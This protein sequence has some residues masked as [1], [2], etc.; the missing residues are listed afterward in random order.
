M[1]TRS[2]LAGLMVAL[3]LAGLPAAPSTAQETPVGTAG[4]ADDAGL[5]DSLDGVDIGAPPPAASDYPDNAAPDAAPKPIRPAR[6]AAP[7]LLPGFIDSQIQRCWAAPV[8]TGD[9]G[10]GGVARIR[11]RFLPDGTLAE[12]PAI[13]DKPAGP[14]GLVFAESAAKAIAKCA[15]YK[16]PPESYESWKDVMLYF[17]TLGN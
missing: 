13:M 3:S 11:V 16:L 17:D 15:P 2:Q 14:R 1:L 9:P 10:E 4:N 12:P 6:P 5:A 7:E 8:M